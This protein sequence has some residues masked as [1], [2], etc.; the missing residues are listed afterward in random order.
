[1]SWIRALGAKVRLDSLKDIPSIES[2][3]KS[4]K[5]KE[6]DMTKY[7]VLVLGLLALGQAQAECGNPSND[8]MEV[9]RCAANGYYDAPGERKSQSFEEYVERTKPIQVIE[10]DRSY[11]AYPSADG[12]TISVYGGTG[13]GFDRE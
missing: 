6:L 3:N 4:C 10:P 11:L 2:H 8:I 5:M 12:K 7:A 1:M 9:S 13:R